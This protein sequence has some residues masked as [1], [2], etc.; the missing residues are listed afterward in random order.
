MILAKYFFT[1]DYAD[2]AD[3]MRGP[4]L[5]SLSVPRT[6]LKLKLKRLPAKHAKP[7]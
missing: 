1:A 3:E 6:F 4:K 2:Y 5:C 7:R